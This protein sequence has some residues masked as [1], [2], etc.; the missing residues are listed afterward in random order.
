MGHPLG[1]INI[2]VLIRER[3]PEGRLLFPTLSL[4]PPGQFKSNCSGLERLLLLALK[5]CTLQVFVTFAGIAVESVGIPGEH[6]HN[7]EY[8]LV[9]VLKNKTTPQRLII[10]HFR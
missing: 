5:G 2:S 6:G 8:T 10:K 1:P 3:V 9:Y 4:P 7:A